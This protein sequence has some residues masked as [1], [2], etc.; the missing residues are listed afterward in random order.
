M[1]PYIIALS[2]LSV[3]SIVLLIFLSI[4]WSKKEEIESELKDTMDKLSSARVELK[5]SIKEKK[6]YPFLQGG[7]AILLNYGL[8]YGRDK[9]FKID[10]E[11]DIIEVSMNKIKVRAYDFI[12]HDSIGKDPSNKQGII[13]FMQNR[14]IDKISAEVIISKEEFRDIKLDQILT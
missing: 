7:K 10:Y 2:T 14:W 1:L 5:N 11:V 8:T 4:M 3:I 12:P 9:D 6:V 13:D